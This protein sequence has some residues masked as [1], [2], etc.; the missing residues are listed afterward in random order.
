M[1]K[2]CNK[3][4]ALLIQLIEWIRQGIYPPGSKLPKASDLAQELD[5]SYVT[6]LK[7]LKN[8]ECDGYVTVTRGQ[9]TYVMNL[10]Q[11]GIPGCRLLNVIGVHHESEYFRHIRALIEEIF[12][13]AN[14]QLRFLGGCRSL[15][16]FKNEINDQD[17]YTLIFGLRPE[18]NNFAATIEHVR[19]RVILMG[20]RSDALGISCITADERQSIQLCMKHF[21]RNGLSRIAMLRARSYDA[22]EQER[23]AVWKSI[24]LGSGVRDC[25]LWDMHLSSAN[26]DVS[27]P[28]KTLFRQL[29]HSG[30]LA[31]AEAIIAPDAEVAMHVIRFLTDHAIR[32]PEDVQVIGIGDKPLAKSNHPQ[33][34]VIDS[35]LRGHVKMALSIFEERL[36]GKNDK[37][38]AY[39]CQPQL[40]LREST[41]CAGTAAGK[42]S[43]PLIFTSR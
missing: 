16:K 21:M 34:S 14:W 43:R 36:E 13:T 3:S 42:T 33:I 32:V 10:P 27:V 17:A 26:S 41:R 37:I 40:I 11:A 24:L 22:L 30:E 12:S 39:L 5:T 4:E 23:C 1:G 9:G 25:L 20:Q 38:A 31:K 29:L 19:N 6:M 28:T 15:T 18:F 35:N 7:V 2:N 8:L